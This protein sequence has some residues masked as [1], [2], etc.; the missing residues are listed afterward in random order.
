M[1]RQ[2][3]TR[4]DQEGGDWRAHVHGAH[5]VQ[6]SAARTVQWCG[7]NRP[8]DGQQHPAPET[9]RRALQ[10]VER[11]RTDGQQRLA[12]ELAWCAPQAVEHG[13]AVDRPH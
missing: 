2:D 13:H 6:H 7:E 1:Q 3:Q 9:G 8:L 10:A 5:V 11:G 12:P 4:I